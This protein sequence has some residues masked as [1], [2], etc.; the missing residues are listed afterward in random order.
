MYA[1]AVHAGT[2]LVLTGSGDDTARLWSASTGDTVAVLEGHTDT[3]GAVGFNS[4]GT[5]VATGGYDCAVKVWSAPTGTLLHT[6]EGPGGEIEWLAWH[7]RGDVLLAGCADATTWMWS[8]SDKSAACMNVFAGHEDA[9]SCGGFTGS[10]K[11]IVTGSADSTVRLW[12]PKTGTCT[13]TFA[14]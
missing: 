3:V 4:A 10:G 6:L 2:G 13:H 14:G 7:P 11:A 12:N 1:V 5:L 9:V 8:V